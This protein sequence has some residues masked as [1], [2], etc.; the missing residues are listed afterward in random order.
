MQMR[1]ADAGVAEGDQLGADR[2]LGERG[3]QT[4]VA[5]SSIRRMRWLPESVNANAPS[6]K[7][8]IPSGKCSPA[9]APTPSAYD[10][11]PLP[12]SVLT[13]Q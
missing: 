10:A 6:D 7:R 9:F 11:T 8:V 3:A 13:F 2:T 5:P 12:T 1:A 4:G